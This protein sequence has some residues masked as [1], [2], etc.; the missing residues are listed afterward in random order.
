MSSHGDRSSIE[1][2]L[3]GNTGTEPPGAAAPALRDLSSILAGAPGHFRIDLERAPRAIADFRHAAA[4]M[5]DLRDDTALLAEFNAPGLDAVSVNVVAEIKHWAIGAEVGSLRPALE[6][7]AARLEEAA[8]AL[9][10]SLR[11]YRRTDHFPAAD[12]TPLEF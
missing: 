12:P 4:A 3:A 6:Q 2:L 5:R 10:R 9:E 11:V 7:G 8:E 1:D